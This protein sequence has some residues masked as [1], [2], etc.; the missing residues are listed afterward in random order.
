MFKQIH[1]KKIQKKIWIIL[2]ILIL[3]AFLFW[4]SGSIVRSQ[5]EQKYVGIIRGKRISPLEY[6]DALRAIRNQALI[7]WGDDFFELEKKLNLESQAW[8]R[9]LLLDEAK[10]KKIKVDD[11]EV[12]D[13]IQNYS[14]FQKDSKFDLET[15]NRL[16]KFTF[17]T[18]ARMFEEQARDTLKISKLYKAVT[19]DVNLSEDEIKAEYKKETEE[20][21]VDYLSAKPSDFINNLEIKEEELKN[22]FNNHGLQFKKPESFNLQYLEV[23]YPQDAKESDINAVNDKTK[24]ILTKLKKEKDMLNVSKEFSLEL[25][26]TGLFNLNNPI[27]GIGWSADIAAIVT[28]MKTNQFFPPIQTTKG[29]YFIKLK[30]KKGPY[31]PGFEE[32]KDEVREKISMIQ[33]R[34]IAKEKIEAALSKIKD[35]RGLK[36]SSINFGKI[37]KEF[38]LESGETDFFKRASYIPNLGISDKFFDI[39]TDLKVG[40]IS[41]VLEME[42]GF[43][44]IRLK[45]WKAID[46]G[47]YL[48]E[49]DGFSEIL[50]AQKKEKLFLQLLQRLK[51]DANLE[52]NLTQNARFPNYR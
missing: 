45:E 25:K 36:P 48:K 3:P 50:L 30:E 44:I 16:L 32:V 18:P 28:K 33:S 23:P 13:L 1:N 12:L 6:Q 9:L 5:R 34:K 43:Y 21:R 17:Y 20:A 31:I 27:P 11:A 35:T 24:S 51:K 8:D 40:E 15:Y 22:Y 41:T 37:A 29:W 4:G 26:E 46:E 47:V 49:K 10:R 39:I 7:I 2:A 14:F 52:I 19:S 42:Q 38:G